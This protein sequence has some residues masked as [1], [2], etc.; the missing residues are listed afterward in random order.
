MVEDLINHMG[1]WM[2]LDGYDIIWFLYVSGSS[3]LKNDGVKVSGD[4]YSI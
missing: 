1:I 2:E 4:D 3:P